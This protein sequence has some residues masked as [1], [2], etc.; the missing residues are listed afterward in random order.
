MPTATP[1][2]LFLLTMTWGFGLTT[3]HW[4]SQRK[5]LTAQLPALRL[6]ESRVRRQS[7]RPPGFGVAGSPW[8]GLAGGLAWGL[9]LMRGDR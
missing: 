9:A 1:A 7:P 8:L 6:A 5:M 2:G 3:V 4:P